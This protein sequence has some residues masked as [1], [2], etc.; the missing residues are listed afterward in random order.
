MNTDK[1]IDELVEEEKPIISKK[2]E[3]LLEKSNKTKE[4]K[5]KLTISLF[6]KNVKLYRESLEDAEEFNKR[7]EN[8]KNELELKYKIDK[9]GL[10]KLR[11]Q[12]VRE[13]VNKKKQFLGIVETNEQKRIN[14]TDRYFEEGKQPIVKNVEKHINIELLEKLKEK[15]KEHN[16]SYL[17]N[18][19]RDNS[20]FEHDRKEFIAHNKIDKENFV[21]LEYYYKVRKFFNLNPDK[22]E[23]YINILYHIDSID[24]TEIN[25]DDKNKIDEQDKLDPDVQ[26]NDINDKLEILYKEKD[27]H[28]DEIMQLIK[29]KQ[30]LLPKI[31]SADELIKKYE[32]E[33]Y[34]KYNKIEYITIE[35]NNIIKN[36]LTECI[37]LIKREIFKDRKIKNEIDEK[38]EE[39]KN[40]NYSEHRIKSEIDK[41]I[42]T[43]TKELNTYFIPYGIDPKEH[44]TMSINQAKTIYAD[45]TKQKNTDM[46]KAFDE[47]YKQE[48]FK[49][50]YPEF[51]ESFPIVVKYMLTQDKFEVNAF[52]R[53]LEKCRTNIAKGSTYNNT[54]PK[55]GTRR[56]TP[57]EEKWLENQAYYTQYLVEEYRKRIG[58][59]ITPTEANFIR[60]KQLE[61]LR[62][63]MMDFRSN[64]EKIA[65][66]LKAEQL[67]NDNKLLL[68]YAELLKEGKIE[69]SEEE[70]ENIAF[71]V[72]E[73]IKKKEHLKEKIKEVE[74]QSEKELLKLD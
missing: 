58:Q 46:W 61:S 25:E 36:E 59:R 57:S 18:I 29:R 65:E 12:I 48:Y 44:D 31:G 23:P 66:K 74:K 54:I 68:E 39:L 2:I 33:M 55:R 15:Y 21:D 67:Q 34:E 16:I 4:E 40:L 19:A 42:N 3:E 37:K 62:N 5:D 11:E 52:K 50:K 26:L 17:E 41:Y 1:T 53:F 32:N 71:A 28:S 43:R 63:E 49:N 30:E 14:N 51:F 73:I 64:F 35:R 45:Y 69:L 47:E 70:Y 10:K 6:N 20:Y 38:K 8:K 27:K 9:I 24:K 22:L 7:M 56:L 13:L 72:E 60:S